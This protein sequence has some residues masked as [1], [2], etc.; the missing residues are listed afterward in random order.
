MPRKR[1]ATMAAADQDS[2]VILFEHKF[3]HGRHKHVF[4]PDGE[5]DLNA[6][7]DK[8]FF[9]K[10]VSSIVVKGTRTWLFYP[11]QDFEVGNPPDDK[12]IEVGPGVYETTQA[13]NPKLR[14]NNI[15]SLEP[16]KDVIS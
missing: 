4:A 16:K 11:R 12:P 3:F 6:T 2:E 8:E 14:D 5:K 13:A 7:D 10:V 15:Q 9:G 1:C